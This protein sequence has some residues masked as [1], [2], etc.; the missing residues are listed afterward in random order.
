MGLFKKNK[1]KFDNIK[2]TADVINIPKHEE[3]NYLPIGEYKNRAI[4]AKQL[5]SN[6][7]HI[8]SDLN[9]R[10]YLISSILQIIDRG[11][12]M[13]VL[14]PDGKLYKRFKTLLFSK[15][16][17]IRY[18]N[19]D[20]PEANTWNFFDNDELDIHNP[21][22]KFDIVEKCR[23]LLDIF[24]NQFFD[25]QEYEEQHTDKWSIIFGAVYAYI[26][27]NYLL[28]ENKF[29]RMYDLIKYNTIEELDDLFE[30]ANDVTN[31]LW[32][33]YAI[34]DEEKDKYLSLSLAVADLLRDPGTNTIISTSDMILS[35]PAKIKSAYF[36]DS[37]PEVLDDNNCINII[38]NYTL[39]EL[40]KYIEEKGL[41][42]IP[43]YFL[44][45]NIEL[46]PNF[47]TFI[48]NSLKFQNKNINFIYTC[49]ELDGIYNAYDDIVLNKFF[50]SLNYITIGKYDEL[51]L[52]I[53]NKHIINLPEG[54]NKE[55]MQR[56]QILIA[57]DSVLLTRKFLSENHRLYY[58][59]NF[60]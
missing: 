21:N 9:D 59:I 30:D 36:F 51:N 53:I 47:Q 6:I 34:T 38:L 11:E 3:M 50:N 28:I 29:E 22:A 20:E 24:H 2:Y 40:D 15:N 56:R 26:Y 16:Y 37:I 18:I 48:S 49:A 31:S 1:V 55:T 57:Q 44:F 60:E 52:E 41:P 46:F 54:L 13:I 39:F 35:N 45:N 4:E 32:F 23:L 10:D 42:Q 27:T 58:R 25:T 12:S 7:L 5:N 43:I 14:D 33:D 8:T 19:I 17:K